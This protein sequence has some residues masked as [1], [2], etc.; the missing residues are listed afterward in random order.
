MNSQTGKSDPRPPKRRSAPRLSDGAPPI[1][2][3]IGHRKTS[4][5]PSWIIRTLR[6]P[7][8]SLSRLNKMVPVTDAVG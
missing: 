8:R 7:G 1:I 2:I 5:D 6:Q 3:Y 4:K